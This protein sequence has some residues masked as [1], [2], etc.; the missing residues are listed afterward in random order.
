MPRQGKVIDDPR[1]V[2]TTYLTG[3]PL[4]LWSVGEGKGQEGGRSRR[5]GGAGGRE[6]QEG[7]RSRRVSG[8]GGKE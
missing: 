5:E 6:E 2:A 8:A 1:E 3:A 4:L 7:G